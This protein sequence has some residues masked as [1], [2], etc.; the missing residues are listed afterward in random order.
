MQTYK[1]TSRSKYITD[2]EDVEISCTSTTR[3]VLRPTI[4][5]GNEKNPE[6]SV[7]ISIIHQRKSSG[8]W[9]DLKEK[10]LSSMKAGE[11]KSLTLDSQTTLNLFSELKKIYRLSK[12][13]NLARG[14]GEYVV[15][16][17]E[18]VVEV[19]SERAKYVNA[20]IE[21]DYSEEVWEQLIESNPD[22]ATKLSLSRIYESRSVTLKKFEEMLGADHSEPDWQKFF[23]S[24][25][26]IFGFGLNYQILRQVTSQPSYGGQSVKGKGTQKGDFLTR[27]SAKNKFTVLVEIKT[28]SADLLDKK[29]RNGAFPPGKDLIGGISQL[30]I[31]A[32]VWETEGARTSVNRDDLER[33]SIYSIQ[34][35]K[36]LVVGHSE[37][38]NDDRYKLE[39]FELFRRNQI[40]V[41]VLT[42][43]ELYERAKFILDHSLPEEV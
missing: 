27:T 6:A 12:K 30:R 13:R 18:E 37:Q 10:P 4:N 17:P 32:S 16:R 31:N 38:L 9:E 35:K 11:I 5:Q 20:L 40:D 43:D 25:K 42:F 36:I 19:D 29:Y 14:E 41:E 7:R 26:W 24:N 15:K 34:P 23:E 22:L 1:T 21:C 8:E 39:S 33:R 28:P 2:L 3:K